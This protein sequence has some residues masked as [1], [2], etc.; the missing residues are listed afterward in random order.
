M[1]PESY[2]AVLGYDVSMIGARSRGSLMQYLELQQP[3]RL[4]IVLNKYSIETPEFV[5]DWQRP[6]PSYI[7]KIKRWLVNRPGFTGGS[8]T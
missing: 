2:I 5:A 8:N 1:Y 4:E 3:D 7:G 6:E